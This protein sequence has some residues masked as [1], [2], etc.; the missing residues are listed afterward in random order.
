MNYDYDLT[1]CVVL[2]D[3]VYVYD[4]TRM[5]ASSDLA[6]KEPGYTF[7]LKSWTV[8]QELPVSDGTLTAYRSQLVLVGGKEF[9]ETT[10]KLWTLSEAGW[11]ESL[12][13]MPTARC[14]AV[15]I[16]ATDPECLIV[17]GGYSDDTSTHQMRG[18]EY[19][20]PSMEVL[21]GDEWFCAEHPPSDSLEGGVVHNGVV[22]V[23]ERTGDNIFCCNYQSLIAS[24]RHLDGD[25]PLKWSKMNVMTDPI[26]NLL[27][28][29]QQLV[30]ICLRTMYACHPPTD[31]WPWVSLGHIPTGRWRWDNNEQ[32]RVIS[33]AVLPTGGLLA[34]QEEH[35]DSRPPSVMRLSLMGK[36]TVGFRG[37]GGGGL[38]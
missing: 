29:G 1:K 36:Y 30:M 19:V 24:C 34:I 14:Q 32:G 5:C 28:F 16:S 37:G 11:Q 2:G 38:Y 6:S 27:P 20:P 10:N 3:K 18:K 31:E 33:S 4:Y 9:T 15:V 21:I 26:V 7:D 23:Y 35:R 8:L 22:Y 12:P 17:M 13:P 25:K